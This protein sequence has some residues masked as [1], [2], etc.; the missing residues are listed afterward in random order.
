[1]ESELSTNGNVKFISVPLI[2]GSSGHFE[3]GSRMIQKFCNV[4]E[5]GIIKISRKLK[6]SKSFFF[7]TCFP[8]F[9]RIVVRS[10]AAAKRY[11][12]DDDQKQQNKD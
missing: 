3:A 11:R 4:E 5:I 2:I 7:F 1:M 6:S 9:P 12:D 10:L 8:V